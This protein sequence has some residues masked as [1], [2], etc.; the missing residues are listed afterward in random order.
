LFFR[1]FRSSY[2]DVISSGKFKFRWLLASSVIGILIS[3]FAAFPTLPLTIIGLIPVLWGGAPLFSPL[4]YLTPFI[5]LPW[6]VWIPVLYFAPRLLYNCVVMIP[7]VLSILKLSVFL[8]FGVFKYFFSKSLYFILFPLLPAWALVKRLFNINKFDLKDIQNLPDYLVGKIA[9][10]VRGLISKARKTTPAGEDYSVK[11]SKTVIEKARNWTQENGLGE[12]GK[13][14]KDEAQAIINSFIIE[15]TIKTTKHIVFQDVGNSLR[16]NVGAEVDDL[17]LSPGMFASMPA[18]YVPFFLPTQAH[19]NKWF[20]GIM[21][22]NITQSL[23]YAASMGS[24]SIRGAERGA[25]SKHKIFAHIVSKSELDIHSFLFMVQPRWLVGHLHVIREELVGGRIV[26]DL[27]FVDSRELK[28]KEAPQGTEQWDNVE[29]YIRYLID[30]GV[31]LPEL[32]EQTFQQIFSGDFQL[33]IK[34]PDSMPAEE[35]EIFKKSVNAQFKYLSQIAAG[36][37]RAYPDEFNPFYGP[38]ENVT[39]SG[40]FPEVNELDDGDKFGIGTYQPTEGIF[41]ARGN[42]FGGFNYAAGGVEINGEDGNLVFEPTGKIARVDYQQ[43]V[44]G[45]KATNLNAILLVIQGQTYLSR[46]IEINPDGTKKVV[47]K[48]K[49][50]HEEF[51]PE[52]S[53]AKQEFEKKSEQRDKAFRQGWKKTAKR[54]YAK[55]FDNKSKTFISVDLGSK[56]GFGVFTG[57]KGFL[58]KWK[59]LTIGAIIGVL[60]VSLY[61]LLQDPLNAAMQS[62]YNPEL[63]EKEAQFTIF[64]NKTKFD[65][66]T[67]NYAQRDDLLEN[68]TVALAKDIFRFPAKNELQTNSNRI[69]FAELL[70]QLSR[71]AGI[72][73]PEQ[74]FTDNAGHLTD[75]F[76]S[77][78]GFFMAV[79]KQRIENRRIQIGGR[80]TS[81]DKGLTEYGTIMVNAQDYLKRLAA[82]F[83]DES[84]EQEGL[85]YLA[86]TIGN[87]QDII[88]ID[89]INPDGSVANYEFEANTAY[90][91]GVYNRASQ[92]YIGAYNFISG[93]T[94]HGSHEDDAHRSG[95]VERQLGDRGREPVVRLGQERNELQGTRS[96]TMVSPKGP[97]SIFQMKTMAKKIRN[98]SLNPHAASFMKALVDVANKNGTPIAQVIIHDG[99]GNAPSSNPSQWSIIIVSDSKKFLMSSEQGMSL[100]K[101]VLAQDDFKNLRISA[102]QIDVI[103]WDALKTLEQIKVLTGKGKELENYDEKVAEINASAAKRIVSTILSSG[104][105]SSELTKVRLENLLKIV[106]DQ[107][108]DKL[109]AQIDKIKK[110]YAKQDK[111]KDFINSIFTINDKNI[112]D[113]I[114]TA[115]LGFLLRHSLLAVGVSLLIFGPVSIGLFT[116]GLIT[117]AFLTPT[118]GS[119][120]IGA[121]AINAVVILPIALFFSILNYRNTIALAKEFISLRKLLE[122]NMLSS[123]PLHKKLLILTTK[124]P[125]SKNQLGYGWDWETENAMMEENLRTADIDANASSPIRSVYEGLRTGTPL[126]YEKYDDMLNESDTVRSA[127]ING[128]VIEPSTVDEE[129]LAT[130]IA[131][132]DG[133]EQSFQDFN[134]DQTLIEPAI[135]ELADEFARRGKLLLDNLRRAA[136]E[137]PDEL[138]SAV[139]EYIKQR[140]QA[141]APL[142]YENRFEYAALDDI[143]ALA[144]LSRDLKNDGFIDVSTQSHR[145]DVKI[146][147]K[148]FG[149]SFQDSMD[150]LGSY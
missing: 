20:W 74:M 23:Q 135:E 13:M 6:L 136:T 142:G 105:L 43:N 143:K 61:G 40:Y 14:T 35:Q 4:I 113:K 58:A 64:N 31:D 114:I 101:T 19:F 77:L 72:H 117:A 149:L 32:D 141:Q 28:N 96:W 63:V 146:L 59:T 93:K 34:L 51:L 147:G 82:V 120:F 111:I 56:L 66:L 52:V 50:A 137:N 69:A 42:N 18:I 79:E 127:I 8:G 118:I 107:D 84:Q 76:T 98:G 67:Y 10:G 85:D 65:S 11:F 87:S 3:P 144:N 54:L 38:G 116:S 148:L 123:I 60:P 112:F 140:K 39:F 80:I 106:N 134:Y 33:D 99:N 83:P 41:Y 15:E 122:D 70:Y 90:Q 44:S 47:I 109:A 22:Q 5:S 21:I 57:V 75:S 9:G 92:R 17:A 30:R 132:D 48:F 108:K 145:K 53:K 131:D 115:P 128:V 1:L 95:A 62:Y 25:I 55:I 119:V 12:L 110:L 104:L 36:Y 88:S 130:S 86:S 121:I 139:N 49:D 78:T 81:L 129:Y 100:V 24:R 2:D 46:E 124:H 26:L 102:E 73:I 94:Y 16:V 89:V 71:N 7:V 37:Y 68:K 133:T 103:H 125:D 126:I 97:L 45:S 29:D 150:M 27:D 138:L 91:Y